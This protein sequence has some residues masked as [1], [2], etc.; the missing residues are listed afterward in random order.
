MGSSGDGGPHAEPD[1]ADRG[2]AAVLSKLG[3]A[4]GL[5]REAR[6]GHVGRARRTARW[7]GADMGLAH[8][9]PGGSRHAC[10]RA[11]LGLAT[12]ERRPA[13]TCTRT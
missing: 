2:C 12:C 6:P 1:S 9:T 10:I 11:D 8:G 3:P 7:S 5:A 4:C 13:T